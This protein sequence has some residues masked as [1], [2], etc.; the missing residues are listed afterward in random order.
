MFHCHEGSN[1]TGQ[2]GWKQQAVHREEL[3]G[4]HRAKQH[5]G[6][7]VELNKGEGFDIWSSQSYRGMDGSDRGGRQLN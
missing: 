5:R 2:T 6:G 4:S 7:D 3:L 1:E